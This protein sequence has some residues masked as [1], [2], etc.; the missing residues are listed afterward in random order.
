MYQIFKKI[1]IKNLITLRKILQQTEDEQKQSKALKLTYLY[2]VFY[3]K[4]SV[5]FILS[6]CIYHL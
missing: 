2:L 4:H 3:F 6:L 5:I 1:Q